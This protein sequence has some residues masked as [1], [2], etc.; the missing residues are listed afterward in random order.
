MN[1]DSD[2]LENYYMNVSLVEDDARIT[3]IL[4]QAMSEEGHHVSSLSSG[5]EVEAYL[6]TNS[7]E[8]VMLDLM[9]PGISGLG[10]LKRLREA[11]YAVPV[12][13]VK[14]LNCGADDYLTNPFI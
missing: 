8:I 5:E 4:V 1:Y 3:D 9:L 13:V 12:M 6:S 14:G 7:F 10:I 11:R 2:S